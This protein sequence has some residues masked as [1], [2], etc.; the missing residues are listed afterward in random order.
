MGIPNEYVL[1]APRPQNI[2]DLFEGMWL[3]EIPPVGGQKLESG[4]VIAFDDPRIKWTARALGGF[5]GLRVLELGPCEGAHTYMLER[6]GARSVVSIEA[7]TYSYLKCLAVKEVLGLKRSRFLLGDF[8]E[9][10]RGEHPSFDVTLASGVLYHMQDPVELLHLIS[11]TCDV[12]AIWTHYFDE[13]LVAGNPKL[14]HRFE[15]G[16]ETSSHGFSHKLYKYDYA[17]ERELE[18]FNGGNAPHSC[19]MSRDAILACLETFGFSSIQIGVDEPDHPNGPAFC[20]LAAND[21]WRM[22]R[23]SRLWAL[24]AAARFRGGASGG[25]SR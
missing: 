21:R 16:I 2:L 17:E 3:C 5:G 25:G 15:E 14:I 19:W 20:V 10:L 9:Y 12:A 24:A 13:S 18:Y 8:V 6:L 23:S 7:N 11:Q 4:Y 22:P 1:D